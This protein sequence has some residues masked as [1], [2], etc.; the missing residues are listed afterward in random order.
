MTKLNVSPASWTMA[1]TGLALALFPT[2]PGGPIR[3]PAF[4]FGGAAAL[5]LLSLA[6]ASRWPWPGEAHSPRSTLSVVAPVAIVAL[7]VA[8]LLVFF[9]VAPRHRG[10]LV[11]VNGAL[12]LI[13]HRVGGFLG[14][15]VQHPGHLLP[16]G[17]VAAAADLVS[18]VM[19]GGPT[20]ALAHS[21]RALSVLTV[22]FPLLGS[23]DVAPALG[24]GDLLLAALFVAAAEVHG[25]G[26]WRMAFCL[27]AGALVTGA[28]AAWFAAPMPALPAMVSAVLLC[29]PG[30]RRVA[31]KDRRVAYSGI[32]VAGAIVVAVLIKQ[33][34]AQ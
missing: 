1:G 30:A 20:Q 17:C 34:L 5:S 29:V 4:A 21:E 27:L 14:A 6:T 3:S 16:A 31:P 15:K 8:L 23:R 9:Y 18:V 13:A 26:R 7:A 2:L 32:V 10:A 19:P 12:V 11:L 24:V 28:S 22:G 33:Q 25:L